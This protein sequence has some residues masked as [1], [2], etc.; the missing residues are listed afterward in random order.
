MRA[1]EVE[2]VAVCSEMW[3]ASCLGQGSGTKMFELC[4]VK[5]TRIHMPNMFPR[6]SIWFDSASSQEDVGIVLLQRCKFQLQNRRKPARGFGAT[7]RH[8]DRGHWMCLSPPGWLVTECHRHSHCI[9][10]S[11]ICIQSCT[12][13]IH[14]MKFELFNIEIWCHY[15]WRKWWVLTANVGSL[16]LGSFGCDCVHVVCCSHSS[17]L[18]ACVKIF[19]ISSSH[20]ETEHFE[21]DHQTRRG[22]KKHTAPWAHV[23]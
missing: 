6:V 9:T 10:S 7:L 19:K 4:C 8:H 2:M 22:H 11:P 12:L 3:W 20:L 15:L 13:H 14:S 1:Q 17:R 21:W 18:Q 5:Q 16:G 23:Y